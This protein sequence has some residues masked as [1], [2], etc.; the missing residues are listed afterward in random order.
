MNVVGSAA[1][2][3]SKLSSESISS[4]DAVNFYTETPQ[5]ELSLDDFE[6]Y[7][8]KRLKVLRKLEQL[9]MMRVP[10]VQLRQKMD[11]VI[12]Q[13]QLSDERIDQASHFIL[14]LSYCQTE[15]LRRWFLR[16]ECDLFRHRLAAL[17]A[18]QLAHSVRD[19]AQ[20][21]PIS[22]Q[23]KER[24]WPYLQAVHSLENSTTRTSSSSPVYYYAVPFDQALELVQQ[25]QC[26]LRHG[27][28]Y[29]AADRVLSI[30]V[31]KFR[32]QLSRQLAHMA[33]AG[34]LQDLETN[35]QVRIYPLLQHLNTCL[36]NDD[37]NNNN[38]NDHHTLGLTATTVQRHS[39]YMP[40]C[41]RQLQTGLHQDGKLK[42]FGRLQYGLF[43]KGAGLSMDQA[44]MFFQRHFSAVTAETFG[45]QYA[46]GI[47][48]LYGREGGK[49]DKKPYHCAQI[50]LGQAPASSGEHHGCPYK[51]YDAT[52]LSALLRQLSIG[53]AADRQQLVH[54]AKQQ[55]QYQL[56]CLKHFQVV[57][58]A[59]QQNNLDN[60]SSSTDHN[61]VN[62]DNVG[63]HP[64]AWFRASVEYH[65]K[66]NNNKNATAQQ[67]SSED[68]TDMETGQALVSP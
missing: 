62:M 44:L 20:L 17:S 53:T 30:L 57:H 60:S 8:L 31:H 4:K 19:Y 16:Y 9:K 42:H 32:A 26:F 15:E 23:E 2:S 45:K 46:Y 21:Q 24:L 22:A 40:L 3:K 11:Q 56:A 38:N 14:R 43:L 25:R 28:A 10:P 52:H 54:L 1:I 50:I 64:N 47:R 65:E 41:M 37:N 61:M 29:V 36:V 35:E 7:A 34:T 13:E 49:I 55:H 68:T 5:Y 67:Q 58:A 27:R 12:K 6:V 63:N 18:E 66:Y 39:R 48:H 51:H 33:Q 59:Q